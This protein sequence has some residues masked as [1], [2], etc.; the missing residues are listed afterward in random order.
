MAPG[1][2]SLGGLSV[3]DLT[4]IVGRYSDILLIVSLF[5]ILSHVRFGVLMRKA[6]ARRLLAQ[7]LQEDAKKAEDNETEAKGAHGANKEKKK[8]SAVRSEAAKE[9]VEQLRREREALMDNSAMPPSWAI[10]LLVV[11]E[12]IAASP[13]FAPSE[14]NVDK[15][16]RHLAKVQKQAPNGVTQVF[17]TFAVTLESV[18]VYGLTRHLVVLA[19][20]GGVAIALAMQECEEPSIADEPKTITPLRDIGKVLRLVKRV[21]LRPRLWA[22]AFLV[23]SYVVTHRTKLVRLC[24]KSAVVDVLKAFGQLLR[25][26]AITALTLGRRQGYPVP[27]FCTIQGGATIARMTQL[28]VYER[29]SAKRLLEWREDDYF[30]RGTLAMEAVCLLLLLSSSVRKPRCLILLFCMFLPCY[31]VVTEADVLMLKGSMFKDLLKSSEILPLL[32]VAFSVVSLLL[33]IAGGIS[34]IAVAVGLLQILGVV[35]NLRAVLEPT[36]GSR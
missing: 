21:L 7:E 14:H 22:L 15:A 5:P 28:I 17:N 31:L 10:V 30:S 12:V 2:G 11:V 33:L 32:S 36:G 35:F 3:K 16:I 4:A 27:L 18:E 34:S 20:L 24:E 26:F 9:K 13:F 25:G 19:G 8:D 6:E 1:S 23:V 29:L